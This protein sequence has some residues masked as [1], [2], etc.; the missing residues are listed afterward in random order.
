ML[1]MFDE[2]KGSKA[3]YGYATAGWN[4]A[5]VTARVVKRVAPLLGLR[6]EGLVIAQGGGEMLHEAKLISYEPGNDH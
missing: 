3:T 4:A 2:P 6:P 1:I 5:P